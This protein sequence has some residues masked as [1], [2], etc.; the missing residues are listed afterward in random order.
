MEQKENLFRYQIKWTPKN[1]HTT[2]G[3]SVYSFVLLIF[4]SHD[5]LY[6]AC[7]YLETN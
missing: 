3:M 6:F 7:P 1:K 2:E 4:L 5:I